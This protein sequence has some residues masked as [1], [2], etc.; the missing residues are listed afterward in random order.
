MSTLDVKMN[1]LS[2]MKAVLK[3]NEDYL[4]NISRYVQDNVDEHA[5]R[6]LC[7]IKFLN[8]E[9][10]KLNKEINHINS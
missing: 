1:E 6:I 10:E 7:N 4:A 5:F 2:S 9:I 8:E 3:M